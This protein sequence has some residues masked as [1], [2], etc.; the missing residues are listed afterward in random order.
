MDWVMGRTPKDAIR[1]LR[2]LVELGVS[3][4]SVYFHDRRSVRV[5]ADEVM[6]A[7]Y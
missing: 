4:V 1:E 6:P 5:F 2:P 3:M 7:F